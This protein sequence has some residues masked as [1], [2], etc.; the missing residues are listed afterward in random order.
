VLLRLK[1]VIFF[2]GIAGVEMRVLIR[3]ILVRVEGIFGIMMVHLDLMVSLK[4]F[5]EGVVEA[6]DFNLVLSRGPFDSS[7]NGV[8]VMSLIVRV[9]ATLK[10]LRQ[11]PVERFKSVVLA[12]VRSV[13][14][15]L[16]VCKGVFMVNLGP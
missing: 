12:I 1:T 9:V 15:L 10:V 4:I 5:S 2:E 8:M 6:L 7:V 16:T 13:D 11:F 14:H 3:E